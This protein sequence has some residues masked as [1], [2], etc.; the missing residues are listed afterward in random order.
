MMSFSSEIC[1]NDVTNSFSINN[2]D[3][4]IKKN[5]ACMIYSLKCI[6]FL[7][8]SFLWSKGYLIINPQ[9]NGTE[10]RDRIKFN[11]S[12]AVSKNGL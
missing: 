12:A 8:I 11:L 10:R 9:D 4:F 6:N 3:F 1:N 2:R 5:I 7:S